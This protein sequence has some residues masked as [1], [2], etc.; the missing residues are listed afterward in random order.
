[1]KS[2][3]NDN[4]SVIPESAYV[5]RKGSLQKD[6]VQKL[7]DASKKIVP[8]IKKKGAQGTLME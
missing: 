8:T 7:K 4:Q 2:E 6:T 5:E 1:M 3:I